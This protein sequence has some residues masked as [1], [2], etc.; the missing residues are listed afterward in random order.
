MLNKMLDIFEVMGKDLQ[1]QYNNSSKYGKS[2][3]NAYKEYEPKDEDIENLTIPLKYEKNYNLGDIINILLDI[4][5]NNENT[6]NLAKYQ[7]TISSN[8][9][10]NINNSQFSQINKNIFGHIPLKMLFLGKKFSGRKTQ[11]KILAETFPLK[12][13][14]IEDLIEKNLE[15][16]ERLEIPIDQNPKY[17]SLKKNELEKLII[18]RAVEEQKFEPLKSYI[19]PIKEHKDKNEKIP[20]F[21]IF[22]FISEIIKQDFPDKSQKE[23]LEEINIKS[24]KKKRNT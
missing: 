20:E 17:K 1:L 7:K 21:I 16:L 5:Y 19:L 3:Y 13:Y 4:K 18:D 24:K 14:N 22:D 11:I 2:Q 12:I 10:E 15:I 9:S 6:N 23:I 8:L